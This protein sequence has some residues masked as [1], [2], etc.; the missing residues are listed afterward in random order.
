MTSS[1]LILIVSVVLFIAYLTV[2]YFKMKKISNIP[3]NENVLEITSDNFKQTVKNGV[4]LVDF[5]ASWCMPCKM[6][7]PILNDVA[8]ELP[9]G[10]RVGKLNIEKYNNIAA[11]L[12][13]RNIPTMILF[14]DG[15]EVKRFVGVKNKDFLL[16][17][18][19][20]IHNS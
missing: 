3:D 6:M 2:N 5:W 14:K 19:D 1:N 18:I 8:N 13:V 15:K 20:L 9:K 10:A 16:K 12:K 11:E 17:E 7:I 4:T